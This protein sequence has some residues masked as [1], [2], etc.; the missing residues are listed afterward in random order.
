MRAPLL[1]AALRFA[2]TPTGGWFFTTVTPPLDRFLLRISQGRWSIGL[3]L[4]P[5]C[6]LHT[7]GRRSGKSYKTPLLYLQDTHSIYLVASAGGSPHHPAWYLNAKEQAVA[8]TLSGTVFN[9]IAEEVCG[10][11]YS[12]VW[13]DFVAFNPGFNVYQARVERK[14]PILKIP[15]TTQSGT[16]PRM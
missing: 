7:T 8:V 6:L 1:Q 15:I 5:I 2:T 4:V 12:R 13:A 16:S 14:I 10:D 9:A 11:E 3:G